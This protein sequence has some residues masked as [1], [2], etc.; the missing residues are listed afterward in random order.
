MGY[1]LNLLYLL[2]LLFLSPWLVYKGL[3][4]GKYRRGFWPKFLGRAPHSGKKTVWFHGVS[5][6]E[7]HLLATIVAAF[8]QRFPGWTCVVST[9]TDTGFDEAQK[10]FP[11]LAVFWWPFDFTWAVKRTLDTVQPDLV[12][13]AESELWPNFLSIAKSRHIPVAVLNARMSPRSFRRFQALRFLVGGL[14]R[15]L[16]LVATQTEEYAAGYR[17][18]GAPQVVVTGSVKYDGAMTRRDNPRTRQ[19]A[20]LL[21]ISAN[22]LVWVAGS[23]QAPEEEI[24]LGIFQKAREKHANLRLILVPRQKDRFEDVARLLRESGMPFLRRSS[25][26]VA[27]APGSPIILVDT[28]GELSAVWGLAD[29]AFVGGSLDGQRG[30]QNMI[31][32]AAYGAAVV[33]GPHTW[34]F[35][36]TVA[37]L[38]ERQG[39]IQVVDAVNLENEVFRL[40]ADSSLRRT[41]G[42]SARQFVLEQQ[43]ATER[44]LAVL[45]SV[46]SARDSLNRVA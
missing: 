4:T 21:D 27:N 20:E 15:K 38:L 5:V 2:L 7:I 22:D 24:A 29:L 45:E 26:P 41:L 28:I 23:T 13:L 14:F 3:T 33:F 30:G 17:S 34:N 40:L 19:M 43:G 32:P 42:N 18:L 39:A 6:G 12:I 11:D 10:K 36:E 1:L 25:S 31:E 16:T 46:M 44:T 37:R 9:T 8:R 35:K